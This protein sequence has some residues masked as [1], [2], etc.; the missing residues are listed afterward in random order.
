MWKLVQRYP[1]DWRRYWLYRILSLGGIRLQCNGNE[2][3]FVCL[4]IQTNIFL[5]C[6]MPCIGIYQ[7]TSTVFS[8]NRNYDKWR[9]KFAETKWKIRI[10][11]SILVHESLLWTARSIS[12]CIY[13]WQTLNKPFL[14]VLSFRW[15]FLNPALLR[16]STGIIPSGNSL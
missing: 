15:I 11:Q 8:G 12:E 10:L 6:R 9:C 7:K 3:E 1:K 4:W 16:D 14:H 2:N 5:C 13:A